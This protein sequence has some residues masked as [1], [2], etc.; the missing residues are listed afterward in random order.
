[1]P[2]TV[3]KTRVKLSPLVRRERL[4]ERILYLSLFL[5]LTL[6]GFLANATLSQKQQLQQKT[7]GLYRT[8]EELVNGGKRFI[9]YY[10]S[11]NSATVELD[12]FRASHMIVDEKKKE[13]NRLYIERTG[14][15]ADAKASNMNSEIDWWNTNA[16]ILEETDDYLKVEYQGYLKIDKTTA[17]PIDMI[18]F[19]VPVPKTDLNTDGV[20]VIDFIDVAKDPFKEGN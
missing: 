5:C 8:Q 16:E 6:I 14:L 20:G 10:W 1:M 9:D 2:E 18:L 3:I 19:L 11:I 12:Q 13:E 4:K 15:V 17:M 7:E